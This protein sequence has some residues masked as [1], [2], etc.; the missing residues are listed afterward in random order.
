MTVECARWLAA[1]SPVIGLGVETVGTD[2]GAAASFD[3][4]FLCHTLMHGADKYGLTPLQNLAK[5]PP[6]G[7]VIAVGP[8]RIAR[9]SGSPARALALMERWPGVNVSPPS[10]RFSY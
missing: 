1:E 7:A 4:M 10:R 3:P 9:G 6:Q 8:L 5:L 2:A